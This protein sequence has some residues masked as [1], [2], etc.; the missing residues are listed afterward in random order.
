MIIYIYIFIIIIIISKEEMMKAN[1]IS[2]GFVNLLLCLHCGAFSRFASFGI[3]SAPKSFLARVVM[4]TQ[5]VN[6]TGTFA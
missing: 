3:A 4:E 6:Q 2:S 5:H 1:P